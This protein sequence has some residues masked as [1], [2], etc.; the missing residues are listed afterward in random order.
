MVG[1]EPPAVRSTLG[2]GRDW[3]ASSSPA[4]R[5]WS[6]S[7]ATRWRIG[8]PSTSSLRYRRHRLLALR[9][10]TCWLRCWPNVTAENSPACSPPSRSRRLNGR[11]VSHPHFSIRHLPSRL[12][13]PHRAPAGLRRR[14][15]HKDNSVSVSQAV[16]ASAVSQAEQHQQRPRWCWWLPGRD[17]TPSTSRSTPA[18]PGPRR[19]PTARPG[20]PC[21]GGCSAAR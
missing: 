5:N 20:S 3:P 6:H 2:A 10:S 18:I 7:C 16:P 8:S 21:R 19:R 9:R 4:H 1:V 11:R 15:E 12:R 17:S 13:H 14:R